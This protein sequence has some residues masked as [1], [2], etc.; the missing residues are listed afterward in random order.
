MSIY[1]HL[2]RKMTRMLSSYS[3]LVVLKL[4][5][6]LGLAILAEPCLLFGY[7]F[8]T[9]Y[10]VN[11]KNVPSLSICLLSK[12]SVCSVCSVCSSN[13]VAKDSSDVSIFFLF[14]RFGTLALLVEGL[15]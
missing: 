3:T 11:S 6:Q 7:Y 12:C 9:K 15:T 4:C 13:S 8:N 1:R 5:S 2:R 14:L 10:V